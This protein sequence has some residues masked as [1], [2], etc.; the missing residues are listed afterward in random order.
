MSDSPDSDT[1][2]EV[3]SQDTPEGEV[4]QDG[5][6]GESVK[7]Q[8]PNTGD[9]SAPPPGSVSL[10]G[11]GKFRFPKALLEGGGSGILSNPIAFGL[12]EYLLSESILDVN[13]SIEGV[14]LFMLRNALANKGKTGLSCCWGFLGFPVF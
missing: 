2:P 5:S 4:S 3:V 9:T 10:F 1:P 11:E 7:E 6:H 14:M 13:T 12:Q 8:L